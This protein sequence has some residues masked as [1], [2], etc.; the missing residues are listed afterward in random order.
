MRKQREIGG[1][2]V[3]LLLLLVLLLPALAVAM[4]NG[5]C[6]GCHADADT[7][8]E[9]FRIDPVT[10]DTTAHAEVGCQ[11]CHA[12]VTDKHPDDGATPSKA[13]CQE[14]HGDIGAEYSRSTHHGNATC[15]DCHNPHVAR[16]PTA[17]SGVDMNRQCEG[18]HGN[19]DTVLKHAEWLPQADLHIAMLPCI[20]CHTASEENVIT[21]YILKR[22]D[23]VFSDGQRLATYA[24]RKAQAGDKNVQSL[25][26]R[27]EG[28][29]HFDIAGIDLPCRAGVQLDIF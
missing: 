7:V 11:Q 25:N 16:G 20:S 15:N 12:S 28:F 29:M 14:C 22:S 21:L 26:D 18:C 3:L 24:E 10:F 17:V 13:G 5:D 6:L 23:G 4:E 8:G 19:L 9:G 1:W 2:L 27:N